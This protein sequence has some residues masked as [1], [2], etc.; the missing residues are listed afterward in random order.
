[1]RRARVETL[2][3]CLAALGV[4]LFVGRAPPARAQ[5]ARGF[6]LGRFVPSER[7]SSWFALDSL[8]FRGQT[9]PAIGIVG[10]WAH[11]PLV[12]RNADDSERASIID[13]QAIVHAGGS[14]VIGDRFRFG[15]S[16]PVAAYQSGETGQVA[17]TT[18]SSPGAA[19]VGDLRTSAD[20]RIVGTHGGPF[21]TAAGIEM[22]AP[23]GSQSGY[24]GDGSFR[25]I[26]RV[27]VA[28]TVGPFVYAGRVG[29]HVR[30]ARQFAD[31]EIGSEI[32]VAAA[33]GVRPHARVVVGPEM[34]GSTALDASAFR[35]RSTPLEALLGAHVDI[36]S[37]LRG[38]V[39]VGTGMA[40][41]FGSPQLRGI[42]SLE[43]VPRPDAP[44]PVEHRERDGG[45]ELGPDALVVLAAADRDGDGV[46]DDVDQC[47]DVPG[48]AS[49]EPAQHGCPALADRDHDAIADG[50]DA[51]PDAP[52]PS[53]PDP[54]K[55]GCPRAVLTTT[56]IRIRDAVKFQFDSAELDPASD[57]VLEAVKRV[58]DEHTEIQRIRIEGH[59]DSVGV[60]IYNVTL[61][62]GRAA[63]VRKWFIAHG[64][65]PSRVES[66]GFGSAQP[67]TTNETEEGRQHNRRVEFH[68]VGA[69]TTSPVTNASAGIETFA[70]RSR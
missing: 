21:T 2:R 11:K 47:V 70:V 65:A 36:T 9:R 53:D 46:P 29:V 43:W 62:E 49:E 18:L 54:T 19:I 68:V 67:L 6:A 57:P 48:V 42:L 1:M 28:G 25:S 15:L 24:T 55:N 3:V 26:P 12:I 64:V 10:D 17:G 58:L 23:T 45:R 14:L 31:G 4:L 16:L 61:S 69:T 5:E 66:K 30:S 33:A 63:S 51:C 59:T 41:G 60:D 50:A 37:E 44:V 22:Y 35:T 27:L 52:G 34:F 20:I 56:V 38:G 8:D 39:G 40:R 13:Q 7:G 32:V